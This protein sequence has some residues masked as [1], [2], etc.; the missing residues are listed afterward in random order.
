MINSIHIAE[1]LNYLLPHE[2]RPEHTENYE[3]FFHL[4]KFNGTVEETTIEYIIRDHDKAKF[5]ARKNKI[6]DIV[7][8]LNTQYGKD[9][10]SV[11]LKDQYYNMLE[12]IEPIMHIIGLAKEAVRYAGVEPEIIPIRGGT[13]GAR[14][15]YMGLP[16]PNIFTGT[17]NGHGRYEFVVL[18]SMEKAVETLINILKFSKL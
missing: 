2:E 8:F 17:H 14:L 12:K 3:G 5:E 15:S 18:E 10:I 13:D 11:E 7:A 16:C 1:R 4:M 6:R 9:L